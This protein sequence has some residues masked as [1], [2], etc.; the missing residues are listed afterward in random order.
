M[1]KFKT[2]AKCAGCTAAITKALAPLTDRVEFD[3]TSPLKVL[4]VDAEVNP[5]DVMKAVQ[6]AGFICEP[7]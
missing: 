6:A 7:L 4:T 2:N 1:M 5:Q 3:L